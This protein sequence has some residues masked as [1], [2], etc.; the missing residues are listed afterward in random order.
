VPA[1]TDA[2]VWAG[3][4]DKPIAYVPMPQYQPAVFTGIKLELG[5]PWAFYRKFYPAHGLTS[6]ETLV[7][8]QSAL[9]ANRELWVPM[10]L[11][12]HSDSSADITLHADLPAGWTGNTED[13][14]Y[15]LEPGSTYPI[16]I[17]LN[18]PAD[19]KQKS[20]QRLSWMAIQNGAAVGKVELS[21]YLEYN[22]VPQ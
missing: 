20:P 14:K 15:H 6:L 8:P 10:L 17:F 3:I 2:D 13:R 9:S 1:Q 16:E 11:H 7:T 21:V 22:D 18:A 19:A 4:T 5:G 12:N